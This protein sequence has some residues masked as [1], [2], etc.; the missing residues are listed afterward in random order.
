MIMVSLATL[1]VLDK[2]YWRSNLIHCRDDICLIYQ[3]QW[4][5]Y[6]TLEACFCVIDL[7]PLSVVTFWPSFFN[8]PKHC[9][10]FA[11]NSSG[12]ERNSLSHVYPQVCKSLVVGV[13][14]FINQSI[15][16][17]GSQRVEDNSFSGG[18]ET[19]IDFASVW[20]S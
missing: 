18:S 19:S 2:F 3:T 15:N 12:R 8:I 4:S 13:C 6:R 5:W 16:E 9:P 11:S 14:S 1:P 10:S 17:T 7:P 20:G